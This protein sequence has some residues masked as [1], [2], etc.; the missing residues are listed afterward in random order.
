MGLLARLIEKIVGRASSTDAWFW[1]D[2]P[3]AT[4]TATGLAITQRTSLQASSV[5]AC[6]NMLAEDVA[7][8]TPK[9]YRRR[10]G[11]GREE[12]TNHYLYELLDQPNEWQNWLEFCEQMQVGLVLKGNAYAVIIR[13]RRGVPVRLVP[14]NP[15]AVM[16]WESP[17]G[18]IFYQV[19]AAGFHLRAILAGLPQLIPQEDVL[20][21]R[22]F[23]TEGLLGAAR[24]TLAREAIGLSI[25]QERQAAK[26]MGNSARPSGMLT[27][28]QKLSPDAAKR[29][30]EDF[31]QAVGGLDNVGKVIVGEQGLKFE[32]FS[33]TSTDLEFLAQRKFQ[34][35]EIAR[36][37]RVPPHMI[38]DLDRSTNNNIVQQS[39]EYVNYTLSGYTR[40]WERKL[41]S[42]F[43]LRREGL[44]ID[45][46]MTEVTRADITS[47]YNNYR[48]GIMSMFITPDE[49]RMDD[50]REPMG[51]EA[52]KLQYPKNMGTG[53]SQSSGD[54]PD[55]AGDPKSDGV[56]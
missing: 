52:A 26:W 37:F 10:E 31:R 38:G 1:R 20:H 32:K 40:R 30:G 8:L 4:P 41:S 15:D 49:A 3:W 39:Q 36:I 56:T 34:V 28:D 27:T 33:M 22:G 53:G 2:E 11:G 55:G 29:I 54:A 5:M 46:D 14:V 18:S 21:L 47:R 50:G 17:D 16:L 44:F 24:M 35:N 51:G 42:T 6:V 9:L 23:S 19:T 45:F 7:K 13:N 25:A 12:A 48:T 43:S